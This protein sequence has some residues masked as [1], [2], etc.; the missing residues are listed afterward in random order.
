MVMSRGVIGAIFGIAVSV[1]PVLVAYMF[2]ATAAL[3]QL[4]AVVLGALIARQACRPIAPPGR[5][6]AGGRK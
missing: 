5:G 1:G 6:R 4:G 3:H 2:P